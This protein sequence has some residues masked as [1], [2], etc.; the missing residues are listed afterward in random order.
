MCRVDG[1]AAAY[2]TTRDI[3]PTLQQKITKNTK[4][5]RTKTFREIIEAR[6]PRNGQ[7]LRTTA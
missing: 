6:Y 2:N 1:H 4:L 3:Q 5:Q 7:P